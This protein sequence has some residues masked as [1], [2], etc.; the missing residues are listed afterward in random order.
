MNEVLPK[1]LLRDNIKKLIAGVL[2]SQSGRFVFGQVSESKNEFLLDTQTGKLWQLVLDRDSILVLIPIT[3]LEDM[4][5][6][7]EYDKLLRG[8]VGENKKARS[9]D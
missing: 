9:G 3:R 7:A 2:T 6:V 8:K 4:A 1:D 5:Q